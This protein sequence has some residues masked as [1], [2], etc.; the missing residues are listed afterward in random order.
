LQLCGFFFFLPFIFLISPPSLDRRERRREK[1]GRE[2]EREGEG[3]KEGEEYN[4]F[5]LV[6]SL[7]TTTNKLQPTP[8]NDH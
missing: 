7:S 1:S 8:L 5:L 3:G 6:S 2:V 4:F